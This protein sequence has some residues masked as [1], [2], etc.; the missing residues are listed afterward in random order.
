GV[1]PDCP[2]FYNQGLFIKSGGTGT[3]NL[4]MQLYN[5]GTVQIDRGI[6]N[7]DC[8]YV[9]V[10]GSGG[11]SGTISGNFTGDVS[12]ANTGEMNSTLSESLPT[13]I[14]NYTQTASG[15]LV[16]QIGGPNP[17]TGY[18][19]IVVNG[20][21]TL[22]GTLRVMLINTFVPPNINDSF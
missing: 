5:S 6:L 3:T 10:V 7:I 22:D 14:N 21:V 20:D 15:V 19:Q 4:G 12:V 11:S 2:I 8:G 17:G 18:G 13:P 9:R 1:H 16:E